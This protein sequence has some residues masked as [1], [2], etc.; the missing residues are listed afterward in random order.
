MGDGLFLI[1]SDRSVNLRNAQGGR[2]ETMT[3]SW[4]ENESGWRIDLTSTGYA[5]DNRVI[6]STRTIHLSD[7]SLSYEMFMETTATNA[8]GLHLKTDLAKQG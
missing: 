3:G 8:M 6:A 1:S 5:G 4:Q 7:A 2:V